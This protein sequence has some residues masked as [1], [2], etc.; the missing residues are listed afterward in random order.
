MISHK[1]VKSVSVL[2]GR[3][4]A[5]RFAVIDNTLCCMFEHLSTPVPSKRVYYS[6]EIKMLAIRRY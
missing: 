5:N 3:N 6:H 2:H 4:A 1:I